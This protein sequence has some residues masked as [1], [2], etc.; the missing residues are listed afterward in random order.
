MAWDI[1]LNPRRHTLAGGIVTGDAE[2]IQRL[3]IRLN[4]ELGEW[5]LN[6]E[7]GLPWYQ[8][9]YGM[10]GAKPQRKN[11]IDLL[12][13]Q[14]IATT[15]GVEQI[16][17][18]TSL[19]A[20]GTRTYSVYCSVLLDTGAARELN[21]DVDS[22]GRVLGEGTLKMPV[23]PADYIKFE[24][25]NTLQ[26]LWDTGALKGAP[27][28][29]GKDGQ[30]ASIIV[31]NVA[32]STPGTDATVVNVGTP[33]N[34]IFDF[35]LPRGVQGTT[36]P[37]GPVGLTGPMGPE[38]P[39]GIDGAA[40]ATGPQGPKGDTGPM[41][42]QG[43]PG[44]DGQ[45]IAATI[46]V[47]T[48]TASAPG[49]APVITN[50]GTEQ[51]AVLN[52]TLPRGDTGPQGA[53]GPQGIQGVKGDTGATGPQGPAGARGA[54]GATG[55][56]G[57]QGIQGPTGATGATGPQGPAGKDASQVAWPNVTT[58]W[59]GERQIG[60]YNGRPMYKRQC[61]FYLTSYTNSLRKTSLNW[62][63][64]VPPTILH[65]TGHFK[66]NGT[67]NPI[68]AS[69]AS[70]FKIGATANDISAIVN[71]MLNSDGYIYENHAN[72]DHNG[73]FCS[74]WITYYR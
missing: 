73:A 38:G 66:V 40:G 6:T 20:L 54:A 7:A 5:F 10:L 21:F 19:Y 35:T 46:S 57:P 27:G 3:W 12:I 32:T 48:V 17:K 4:R 26:D 74:V 61:A 62:A 16:L 68:Y 2:I 28:E 44:K 42:P 64:N 63:A 18:Y 39:K 33:T 36:G 25:G 47:G 24:D 51:D 49:S 11:D 37:Q 29:P 69:I 8:H 53:Q 59:G 14:E 56:Q 72:A 34:A 22:M 1:A 9:G 45:G 67:P 30:A 60:T 15:E 13:R 70:V 55:P 31:G 52:F 41:G 50:A 58:G 43:I 23:I 71:I 65:I